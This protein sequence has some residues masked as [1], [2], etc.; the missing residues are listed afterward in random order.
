M[1]EIQ[2]F[3]DREF[4]LKHFIIRER[5][6]FLRGMQRRPGETVQELAAGIRKDASTCD[7]TSITDPQDEALRQRFIYSAHDVTVLKPLFKIS[8][9]ELTFARALEVAI[10][11]EDAAKVAKETVYGTKTLNKMQKNKAKISSKQEDSSPTKSE[12]KPKTNVKCYRCGK[13][14]MGTNCI[15]KQTAYNYFCDKT[16][17]IEAFV[18]QRKHQE[19]NPAV[20]KIT[21]QL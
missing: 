5:F 21:K 14:H 17:H 9:Q 13:D 18:S 1:S 3:T 19:G 4:D 20:C 6:K 8:D 2:T 16:G 10:E 15:H 7:F 11:T 12:E